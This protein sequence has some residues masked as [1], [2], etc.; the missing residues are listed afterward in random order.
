MREIGYDL[1]ESIDLILED[2]AEHIK[3]DLLKWP[4]RIIELEAK[5]NDAFMRSMLLHGAEF[6]E[7][8]D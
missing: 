1:S 2:S 5:N 6:M 3:V 4:R 7:D 8:F